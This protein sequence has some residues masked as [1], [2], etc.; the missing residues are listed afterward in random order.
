MR[1]YSTEGVR[2][3]GILVQYSDKT[4]DA[5]SNKDLD[6]LIAS[7]KIIAFRRSGG[8]VD[9]S[10]GPLRGQ[11]PRQEYAGPERRA[12]PEVIFSV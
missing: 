10:T 9:V 3:M 11:G 1:N 2:R 8:W 5:V 6:T 4:F 12:A 7:R